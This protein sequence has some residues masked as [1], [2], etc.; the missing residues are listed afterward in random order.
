MAAARQHLKPRLEM[1]P[2]VAEQIPLRFQ[3]GRL[4]DDDLL[5]QRN[6]DLPDRHDEHRIPAQPLV[7]T[8]DEVLHA[9]AIP[10]ILFPK[11]GEPRGVAVHLLPSL[12]RTNWH[13]LAVWQPEFLDCDPDS[14]VVLQ[15]QPDELLDLLVGQV[16]GR[17]R[18]SCE[19]M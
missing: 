19:R 6:R 3:A 18:Q 7:H 9:Q 11:F 17:E 2:A 1:A 13:I 14:R 15:A 12:E 5:A 4:A 16:E 8:A 10:H